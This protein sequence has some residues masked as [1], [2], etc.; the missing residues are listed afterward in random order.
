MG[1]TSF[2]TSSRTTTVTTYERGGV[3]IG[4][5][6]AQTDHQWQ[7]IHPK[8]K[9]MAPVTLLFPKLAEEKTA[10]VMPGYSFF[11]LCSDPLLSNGAATYNPSLR[12]GGSF[13]ELVHFRPAIKKTVRLYVIL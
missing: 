3:I 2:R 4:L 5:I 9:K 11:Y 6:S 1:E 13:I 10:K 7:W 12:C 8:Y